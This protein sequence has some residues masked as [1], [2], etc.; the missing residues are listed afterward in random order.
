MAASEKNEN[1]VNK[2]YF[3]YAFPDGKNDIRNIPFPAIQKLAAK[4]RFQKWSW[5]LKILLMARLSGATVSKPSG[6]G[7]W[8]PSRIPCK[9]AEYAPEVCLG[10]IGQI[11]IVF[12]VLRMTVLRCLFFFLMQDTIGV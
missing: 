5:D 7:H 11:V 3:F 8:N 9:S 1:K 2:K 10:N 6:Q 12:Q 4:G